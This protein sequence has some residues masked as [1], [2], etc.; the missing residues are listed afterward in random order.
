MKK[1]IFILD[2]IFLINSINCFSQSVE[3]NIKEFKSKTNYVYGYSND[4]NGALSMGIT[5]GKVISSIETTYYIKFH[6]NAP[7]SEYR[8]DICLNRAS[9]IT[10][11]AKSGRFV[12]LK[13]T[14]VSSLVK[15][16]KQFN[17]PFKPIKVYYN[18][19]VLILEVTKEELIK[20]S[21]D[22]F[23]EIL[24][25]Y[26]NCSTK[27]YNKVVFSKPALFTRRIFTQKNINYILDI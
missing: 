8:T 23:Y 27:V 6:I 16:D 17:D 22:P 19:T 11:L 10:F 20:I 24:L 18:S 5:F 9:A 12:D 21:S 3:K 7:T 1:V 13:L 26:F 14:D 15:S 25:P 4:F 2:C